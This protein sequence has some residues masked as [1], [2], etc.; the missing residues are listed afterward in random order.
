MRR[1]YKYPIPHTN[2]KFSVILPE[3]WKFMRVNF[4]GPEL[5]MW[6]EV[7]PDAKKDVVHFQCFG[8]G[9]DIPDGFKYLTS[10]DQGPFVYHLYLVG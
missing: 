6:A 2:P 8:T 1:A 10:F 4:Q 3:G 9:H 7:E 5:M